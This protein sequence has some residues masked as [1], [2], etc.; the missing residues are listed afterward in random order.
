MTFASYD[1][2]RTFEF[3]E[4]I[5]EK[6]VDIPTTRIALTAPPPPPT[7]VHASFGSTDLVDVLA[8]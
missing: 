6:I 1:P 8:G 3:K 7:V 2:I 5:K 4:L